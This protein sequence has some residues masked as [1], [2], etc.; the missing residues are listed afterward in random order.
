MDSERCRRARCG[1]RWWI[2]EFGRARHV[3]GTIIGELGVAVRLSVSPGPTVSTVF[4]PSRALSAL[5]DAISRRPE[6]NTTCM[7]GLI[8]PVLVYA[9]S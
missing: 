7:H 8:V 1:L 6:S 9:L 4:Q 5:A 2:T 3:R